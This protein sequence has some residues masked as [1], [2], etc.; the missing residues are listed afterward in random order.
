MLS[1]TGRWCDV[2]AIS[3]EVR[4][5][6]MELPISSVRLR[7]YRLACASRKIVIPLAC[8]W[9]SDAAQAAYA[10]KFKNAKGRR[11]CGHCIFSLANCRLLASSNINPGDPQEPGAWLCSN[12]GSVALALNVLPFAGIAFLWFIGVLRDR[13]GDLEDRFF[14]TV[15]FGSALLFLAMLFTAAALTG[16][17]LIAFATAPEKLI[18]SA[19]FQLARAAAYNLVNVYM[20]KMASVFMIATSTVARHT[21]IMPRWLAFMG[22]ALAYI[23]LFGSFYISWRFLVFLTWVFLISVSF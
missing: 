21:A 14:S 13:L 8:A 11:D 6:N 20:V 18:G 16:A 5:A 7:V 3:K 19:S 1:L 22:F 15:F 23:L 2:A 17:I 9:S 12:S 4:W 10:I